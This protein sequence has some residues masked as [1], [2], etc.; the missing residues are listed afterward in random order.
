MKKRKVFLE[1]RPPKQLAVF[2][3][4]FPACIPEHLRRDG[5]SFE[6]AHFGHYPDVPLNGIRSITELKGVERKKKRIS[7]GDQWNFSTNHWW[8][9]PFL[10][11]L[12]AQS[13]HAVTKATR[14][15]IK[16]HEESSRTRGTVIVDLKIGQSSAMHRQLQN[17]A[18][19]HIVHRNTRHTEV[20]D[21]S[22]T[23]SAVTWKIR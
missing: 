19:T 14:H 6:I 17:E 7:L 5:G 2:L 23:A 3:H 21:R 15:Q 8:Q 11:L 10:H 4:M 22:L 18:L 1:K 9:G 16:G 12:K 13:K 20:I